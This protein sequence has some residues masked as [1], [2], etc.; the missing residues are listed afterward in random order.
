M[1]PP[2]ELMF[3]AV[4]LGYMKK[5]GD[6]SGHTAFYYLLNRRFVQDSCGHTDQPL[7]TFTCSCSDEPFCSTALLTLPG[8]VGPY[9]YIA[10]GPAPKADKHFAFTTASTT[11]TSSVI[12]TSSTV[13][14]TAGSLPS[15]SISEASTGPTATAGPL[16]LTSSDT[17]PE[18]NSNEN[19]S[20]SSS[21]SNTYSGPN[22]AGDTGAIIGG[23]VGGLAVVCGCTVAVV[24]I[25]RR[26]KGNQIFYFSMSAGRLPSGA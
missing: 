23:A 9:S 24:W 21:S 15:Q 16:A 5:T 6:C 11:S 12:Q 25:I 8:N 7:T 18:D 3:T 17:E 10:Y 2:I 20:S 1:T 14:P 26:N 13:S 4:I 19:S 22:T